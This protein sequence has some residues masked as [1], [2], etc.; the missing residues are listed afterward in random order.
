M[1]LN[2]IL[3]ARNACH[4]PETG[5]YGIHFNPTIKDFDDNRLMQIPCGHCLGCLDDRRNSWCNRMALELFLHGVGSFITLT[6]A[7]A[8]DALSKPDAQN[9]IK[10]F[11]HLERDYGI[12]LPRGF[13]YFLCGERGSRFGRPHY[14]AI[15]FGVDMYSPEWEPYIA[16]YKDDGTPIWSSKVL[17]TIWAK[18]FVT[19][20][21][22][23]QSSIKYVSKY[24]IKSIFGDDDSFTLKSLA[25]G[26]DM[27]IHREREGRRYI[28]SYR[29]ADKR[30]LLIDGNVRLPD[31]RGGTRKVR[32]PSCYNRYIERINLDD[33]ELAVT[34]R[35]LDAIH[36]NRC[37]FDKQSYVRLLTDTLTKQKRKEIL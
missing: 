1:C 35:Q 10:R 5:K 37:K 2:P 23:T 32:L 31:G 22:A 13:K 29:D 8:P 7:K 3:C 33:Y 14:H 24:I 15:M 20:G 6:Y 26:V 19:I 4:N 25:I 18:G 30:R 27:F 9:F 28:Y 36:Y 21:Q 12:S 16:T 34:N 17:E 11:R